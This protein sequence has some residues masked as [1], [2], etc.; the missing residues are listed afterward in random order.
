MLEVQKP[1]NLQEGKPKILALGTAGSG[2]TTQILTFPGKTFCYLFDPNA[3]R[4]LAGAENVDFVEI[5]PDALPIGATSLSAEN[6]KSLPKPKNPKLGLDPYRS[7]DLDF[8]ERLATGFFDSY[9]NL[10]ID[11]LTS[12]SDLVM[13]AVLAINGRGGQQ[14]QLD[15]YGPVVI[16]LSN[17]CRQFVAM[18]KTI[19]ITG[20][21]DLRQDEVSKKILNQPL[22]IG[23]LKVKLPLLFTDALIFN[24]ESEV[25]GGVTAK[26][27]YRIQT[28]PDRFNPSVRCSLKTTAFQE[29]VTI[30]FSK[31]LLNQGLGKLFFS[32]EKAATGL[33]TSSEKGK[34]QK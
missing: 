14:P 13:D 21:L 1:L 10:V 33:N 20:H 22:L 34:I 5:L 7:F 12:L 26:T 28:K 17:I 4:S 24:A 29:V 25:S 15:D 18:D 23:R 32:P 2:K 3:T 6:R 16:A 9:D 31:P 30:D 19:Y 11:S 8:E 27:S